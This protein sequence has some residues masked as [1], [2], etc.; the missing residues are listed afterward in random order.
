MSPEILW[1]I[2]G[3]LIVIG[4]IGIV[5]PGVPGVMAI[6]GGMLLAAWI[7]HFQRVSIPTI[8][9]LG[10]L[11]ALAF[12]VDIVGGLLGAQRVGASRQALI[13]AALGGLL[14]LFFGFVGLL[15]GPFVGA[16]VGEF[17]AQRRL[18]SAARVG[19]GTGLGLLVGAIAKMALAVA[20]LAIFIAAW[21]IG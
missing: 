6:F 18:D 11:T 12:V 2:A 13:G 14:G 1:L 10:V 21:L 20:M 5:A 15:L 3:A 19:L 17:L 16:T 9:L 7:D 4:L 8:V